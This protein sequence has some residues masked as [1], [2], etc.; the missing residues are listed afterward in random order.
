MSKNSDHLDSFIQESAAFEPSWADRA[1]GFVAMK[2]AAS[3]QT[4]NRTKLSSSAEACLGHVISMKLAMEQQATLAGFSKIAESAGRHTQYLLRHV[5]EDWSFVPHDGTKLA[6]LQSQIVLGM[7]HLR[8]SL[9]DHPVGHTVQ[10]FLHEDTDFAN[11]LAATETSP[12]PVSRLQA[13]KTASEASAGSTAVHGRLVRA[14]K[15]ASEA[16]VSLEHYLEAE[17]QS[18]EMQAQ[19]ELQ[20]TRQGAQQLAAENEQL[21]QRA[22]QAEEALAAAE[23]AAAMATEQQQLAMQQAADSESAAAEQANAKLRMKMKIDQMRQAMAD[24]A[25]INPQMDETGP[26][27]GMPQPEAPGGP[28]SPELGA[29]GEEVPPTDAESVKQRNEAAQAQNEAQEQTQQAE[30]A[31]QNDAAKIEAASAGVPPNAGAAG[32]PPVN[33][34]V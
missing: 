6:T 18:K 34:G 8:D 15:L 9:G 26:E 22:S 32:A 16:G 7:E 4:I 11:K 5:P 1:A 21:T 24:L 23:Q 19:N 14:I 30:A 17:N 27:P 33:P 2:K 28:M 12:Q 29:E 10:A 3:L 20:H 13:L 25:A 31:K